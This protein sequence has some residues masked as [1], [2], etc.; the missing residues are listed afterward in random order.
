MRTRDAN[1]CRPGD[2]E[3]ALIDLAIESW[4]FQ[5][6]FARA[7]DKLDAGESLRFANQHRYFVQRVDECLAAAGL[8]LV[9]LEGHPYDPGAAVT[10]LNVG[11]FS[12][13]D[14]LVIDHMIE[15][16]VMGASGLLKS[17]TVMLRKAG[18]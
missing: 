11:D 16:I 7:L 3:R 1:D 15:P 2:A 4:R 17:G 9:S 13:E 6:L 5:R 18:Q 8:K 14:E 12:A 10:A